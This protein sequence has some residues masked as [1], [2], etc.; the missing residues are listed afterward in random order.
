MYLSTYFDE[1]RYDVFGSFCLVGLFY[2]SFDKCHQRIVESLCC[3][4]S[5]HNGNDNDDGSDND[6]DY[7]TIA[8]TYIYIYV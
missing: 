6:N 1:G 8:Y 3:D 2:D 5:L 7:Y 4:H